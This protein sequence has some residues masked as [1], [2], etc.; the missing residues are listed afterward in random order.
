[1]RLSLSITISFS[2][3]DTFLRFYRTPPNTR[4]KRFRQE[5]KNGHTT[6]HQNTCSFI[7]ETCSKYNAIFVL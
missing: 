6:S 3:P 1:M 7:K 2:H 5:H 4:V